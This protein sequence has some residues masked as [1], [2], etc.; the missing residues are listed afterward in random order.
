V[1]R[2]HVSAEAAIG[3]HVSFDADEAH[4]LARVM[5]LGPGD[6]VH[7]LDGRGHELTVRLT[8]VAARAAE[9]T[10]VS[11]VERRTESPLDLVLA[12]GIPRG[13]KLESII[14]MTTELGVSRIAPLVT[15][16][17]VVRL[18]PARWAQRL[19]RCRRVAREAAKQ[20]GRAV[21]P[22]VDAPRRLD[23]W[24]AG[25]RPPGLVLCL[26]EGASSALA[27]A[28]PP[29]GLDHVTAIVGPEGGLSEAEVACAARA[30]AVVAGM[31][32]RI[33]R[34]ETAGPAVVALLQA[35]YGDLGVGP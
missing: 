17:T 11:R 32:P 26:W 19:D 5:R 16:R 14:R 29:G 12:Q 7:A 31:G 30:G 8:R 15:E 9:G 34:T 20:S 1:S 27:A 3:E 4:H 6:V 2:F 35:R 21:I 25:P 13:D 22:A 28:L 33:L 23:E 10:V 18:D 24:L